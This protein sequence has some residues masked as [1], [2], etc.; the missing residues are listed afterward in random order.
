MEK[1]QSRSGA[2]AMAEIPFPDAW[3][4][5]LLSLSRPLGGTAGNQLRYS[6]SGKVRDIYE[7]VP[8]HGPRMQGE[9]ALIAS[10]RMSAFDTVL[11]D[12]V[13]DKGLVVT[14]LTKF[15]LDNL[16]SAPHHLLAWRA[17][18][19]PDQ[20]SHLAGRAV[21]VRKLRMI[22]LECV[23][24]GHIT[25]SAWDE[26]RSTGRVGGEVM[27]KGMRFA[28]PFP[29]PLFTP[30]LKRNEG[31]QNLSAGAAADLVGNDVFETLKKRSLDLYDQAVRVARPRGIVIA[32]TKFEFGFD[33]V[34]RIALADEVL[35]PDSSR[36]WLAGSW[37]PGEVPLSFDRR[38]IK[39]WLTSQRWNRSLPAPHIPGRIIQRTADLYREVY[40][41]LSNHSLEDWIDA[42][43]R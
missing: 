24:R 20:I 43:R 35:T 7:V 11:N 30:A 40:V 31:D 9:L 29:E 6:S 27:P 15:W 32:D 14:A 38:A 5:P 33:E 3:E 13:P 36:F 22:P 41:R 4:S 16:D 2:P 12:E 18:D 21:V 28:D 8:P 26:Y 1:H 17:S 23:V 39:E 42:A 34:G 19:L 25:G 10:D 37:S